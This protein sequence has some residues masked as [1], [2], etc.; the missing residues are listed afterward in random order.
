MDSEGFFFPRFLFLTF[1][2]TYG[3]LW[4]RSL[5]NYLSSLNS[6]LQK[7]LSFEDMNSNTK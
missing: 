5:E 6:I 3:F 1:I 7:Q 2:L 4:I